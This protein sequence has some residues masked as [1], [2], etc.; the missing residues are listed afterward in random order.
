MVYGGTSVSGGLGINPSE[1]E[2][3]LFIFDT[4][5]KE[6]VFESIPLQGEKAIGALSFDAEGNLWGMSPGK[7][8]KFDIQTREVVQ[9]K[10]LFPFS[11]NGVDHYWRGAFLKYDSDGSLYGSSLGKLF[12]FNPQTWDVDV[13]SNQA[14]LFTKDREGNLYFSR[15]TDLYRY[16]R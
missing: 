4:S 15:G 1:T 5:S 2:A 14:D 12:R 13:L 10:E 6:K 3:K 8:F 11:W 16:L 9:S 7:I